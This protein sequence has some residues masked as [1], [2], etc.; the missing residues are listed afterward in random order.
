MWAVT[1]FWLGRVYSFED[2]ARIVHN[3]SV[4][5]LSKGQYRL[6]SKVTAYLESRLRSISHVNPLTAGVAYTR[7]FIF[8]STLSTTF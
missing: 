4:L 2:I 6:N 7:V 1:A 5:A 8:I 3:Q